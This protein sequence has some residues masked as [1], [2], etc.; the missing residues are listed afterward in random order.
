MTNVG[1]TFSSVHTEG[2]AIKLNYT[3]DGGCNRNDQNVL[4]ADT[5]TVEIEV[6]FVCNH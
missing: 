5:E 4:V 3:M 1:D 2:W 6:R